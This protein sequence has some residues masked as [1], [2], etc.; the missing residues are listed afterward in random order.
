MASSSEV[1]SL[2]DK[3]RGQA[4]A[5]KDPSVEAAAV[6]RLCAAGLLG[7]LQPDLE[8]LNKRLERL[9]ARQMDVGDRVA[10]EEEKFS[11]AEE[12]FRLREMVERTRR[13][14]AKVREIKKEM[15]AL[16]ERSGRLTARAVALME[17]KQREAM[18]RE[19]RRIREEEIEE[20]LVAKPIQ[21]KKP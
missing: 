16:R 21:K 9:S 11:R 8:G 6:S 12:Q 10:A 7:R 17:A 2:E 19:Q 14:G 13:Y 4:E 20:E 15:T 3:D 1:N 18:D 5:E